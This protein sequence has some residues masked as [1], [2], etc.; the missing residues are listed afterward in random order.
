MSPSSL[1]ASGVGCL[2]EAGMA[3]V[4]A[5]TARDVFSVMM[6]ASGVERDESGVAG[7][8]HTGVLAVL[9]LTG[10]RTGAG[11]LWCS[12]E[13]ACKL[14][15]HL[16]MSEY[17][18]PTD[19]VLDAVGEIAN[20]IIG[21]VKS[22]LEE[23]VGTL[24]LGTPTVICG[25]E[26]RARKANT[27]SWTTVGLRWDECFFIAGISLSEAPASEHPTFSAAGSGTLSGLP[28]IP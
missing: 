17:E 8:P 27:G 22:D 5:D 21:N 20:M 23:V 4:L 26:F 2:K 24:S 10:A 6:G 25:A 19:E 12:Q 15:G 3:Q 1:S 14:A 13:S 16:L 18:T 28:S 11:M 7:P 9:G